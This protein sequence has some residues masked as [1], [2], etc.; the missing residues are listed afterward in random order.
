[1]FSLRSKLLAVFTFAFSVL[2]SGQ[3]AHAVFL[4]ADAIEADGADSTID[5]WFF[6]VTSATTGSFQVNDLCGP[7]VVGAD[8]DLIIYLDDGTFGSI[9]LSAVGAGDPAFGLGTVWAA[10]SYVAVIGNNALAIGDLGPFQTDAAL[11]VS[12]YQYEVNGAGSLQNYISFKCVAS[13]NLDGTYT[14]NA[15]SGGST[16]DCKLPASSVGEPGAIGALAFGLLGISLYC[17]RRQGSG[18][19]VKHR[20]ASPARVGH[21]QG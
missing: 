1:M 18:A 17:R 11:A 21:C 6:D 8:P 19:L 20:R 2:I 14:N 5:L 13:G 16:D 15:Y 4:E 10:N 3:S 12:G 7:C 9:Y